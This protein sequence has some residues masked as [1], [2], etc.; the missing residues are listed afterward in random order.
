MSVEWV[1]RYCL[2]FPH[3]TEKI[4]WGNDLVFKVA[5]KMFAV[6]MLEPGD[7]WLSFKCTPE[8][9]AELTERPGIIPAPYMARAQ[10][11][12]LERESALTPGEMKQLLRQ[13]YEIVRA[14]LPR[15]VQ[16]QLQNKRSIVKPQKLKQ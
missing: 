5:E 4:Q 8:D 12:A 11:V 15:R 10:W 1:R 13:S 7:V 9:F 2:S 3:V 16:E 14:K 6:V